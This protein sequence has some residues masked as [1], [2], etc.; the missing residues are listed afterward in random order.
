[1]DKKYSSECIQAYPNGFPKAEVACC[2]CRSVFSTDKPRKGGACICGKIEC[3]VNEDYIRVMFSGEKDFRYQE[4][5]K[6]INGVEL[7]DDSEF[8]NRAKL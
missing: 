1:M 7:P 4:N 5:G 6:T 8:L 2:S 3:D